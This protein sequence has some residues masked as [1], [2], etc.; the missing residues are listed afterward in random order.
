MCR[1]R[2]QP[3]GPG[4]PLQGLSDLIL[5]MQ[6]AWRLPRG[7]LKGMRRVSH[8]APGRAGLPNQTLGSLRLLQ[9]RCFGILVGYHCCHLAKERARKKG[10]NL[11]WASPLFLRR[12]KVPLSSG[13]PGAWAILAAEAG[14]LETWGPR[15]ASAPGLGEDR[16]RVSLC[17]WTWCSRS[18]E[19]TR[20]PSGCLLF[21]LQKQA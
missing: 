12:K 18:C 11:P 5:K 2:C 19:G 7:L 15:S 4:F 10:A 8:G 16:L 20:Q 21:T 6:T 14:S 17:S 3:C 13:S 9:P 1:P